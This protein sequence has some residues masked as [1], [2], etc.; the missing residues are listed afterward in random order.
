MR[1]KNKLRATTSDEHSSNKK[2]RKKYPWKNIFRIF[3][4]FRSCAVEHQQVI[5]LDGLPSSTTKRKNAPQTRK[6][7]CRIYAVFFF[8]SSLLFASFGSINIFYVANGL[9]VSSIPAEIVACVRVRI[10][11]DMLL[12]DRID[13]TGRHTESAKKK[14]SKNNGK[15]KNIEEKKNEQQIKL[16]NLKQRKN[17]HK[18]HSFKDEQDPKARVN[19]I[20]RA[21]R[22][23]LKSRKCMQK[24]NTECDHWIIIIN[25]ARV[26]TH[27]RAKEFGK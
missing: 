26:E 3:L 13:I 15:A 18:N 2:K 10:T 24:R 4:V 1:A 25:S 14:S 16:K 8:I 22:K 27:I 5:D 19:Y 11:L 6:N 23:R 12:L 9:H 7:Q 21:I 17:S 20:F